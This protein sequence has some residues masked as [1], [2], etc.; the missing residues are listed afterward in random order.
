VIYEAHLRATEENAWP[1]DTTIA[2]DAIDLGVAGSERDLHR[3]LHDAALIEGYLPVYAARLMQLLWNDIDATAVLSMELYEGLK[4]FTALT[5][6]LDRVGYQREDVSVAALVAA[7]ERAL[8]IEYREEDLVAHLTNFMCSELFAAYFFLRISRRTNEPVLRDLLGYMARDEFRHSASAGDV[9]RNRID[10]N[11]GVAAQVLAAAER[12]R[13]YGSDVVQVPVAE[14]N[15]F[16][17]IMAVNRKIRL[18][19]GLAPTEHLKE[20]IPGGD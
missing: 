16:E 9:L 19:C 7:R 18:V 8:A 5:R 6:Y 10:G 12:F 14:E 15:D 1:L 13:H 17:A 11:P 20:S 4:H 3:T 2:W